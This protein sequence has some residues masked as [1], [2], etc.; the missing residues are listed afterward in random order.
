ML[1]S[2]PHWVDINAIWH[3]DKGSVYHICRFHVRVS[4]TSNNQSTAIS[5]WRIHETNSK[6][7]PTGLQ[8][9]IYLIKLLS[10]ILILL[11]LPSYK[12]Q[13]I[14]QLKLKRIKIVNVQ[15]RKLV[16]LTAIK[17]K[18]KISIEIKVLLYNSLIANS[19]QSFHYYKILSI[20][21][22]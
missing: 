13:A 14:K 11:F 9:Y 15:I 4:L 18:I 3:L 17:S 22:G 6:P 21:V 20:V 10:Q 19:E 5:S 1:S 7:A 2:F 8:F 16:S 12:L